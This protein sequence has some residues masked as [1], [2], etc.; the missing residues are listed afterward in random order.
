MTI[1]WTALEEQFLGRYTISFK[2]VET[3]G[4]IHR[5]ALEEHF[6]ISFSIQLIEV[7]S[8]FRIDEVH[9]TLKIKQKT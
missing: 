6:L 1:H 9:C 3:Y 5:K 4:H 7:P 8:F 2:I